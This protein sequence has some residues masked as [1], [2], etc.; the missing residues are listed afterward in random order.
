MW[1][2]PVLL[3]FI[4]SGIVLV[5]FPGFAILFWGFP[6]L[7]M[8]LAICSILEL[9]PAIATTEPLVFHRIC[10]MLVLFAAFWSYFNGI[11]ARTV[12]C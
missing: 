7:S 10:N 9:E 1:G 4:G 2:Y 11:C 8:F 5:S 6:V 3:F 12:T